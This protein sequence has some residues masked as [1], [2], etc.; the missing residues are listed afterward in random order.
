LAPAADATAD[1]LDNG[2]S[3]VPISLIQGKIELD[4]SS[5]SAVKLECERALTSL[6]RGNHTKSLRLM[7]EL[8]TKNVNTFESALVHRVQGTVCVKVASIM[9]DPSAKQRYLRNAIES[10]R[11]A[12][13]LSPSSIEFGHFYANLLYE[14]ASDGREYEEVV[15]E[16][17]RALSIEDPVDPAK[18]SL[19]DESQ[20]K[21]STKDG[22]ITHVQN[23]L[24]ALISKSNFSSIS[25]WMKTLGNGEEKFRLIPIR[26]ATEDPMEINQAPARRPN[27]I[28]KATKTPEE[29]RKEIEV[30]VAA[31]RLL[32]QKS[33]SP[34]SQIDRDKATDS[35]S[36]SSQRGGER[37]KS[38]NA[39]KNASSAE[40]K[41]LIQSFWNSMSIDKKKGLL[42]VKISDLKLHFES[43][44]DMQAYDELLEALSVAED[45]RKWQSWVCCHCNKKFAEA[46]S[47]MRHV[48]DE[49][50]TS[51]LPR[52]Q[53][54]LPRNVDNEWIEM[55]V[56]W[57]WKPL[58]VNAAA[59]LTQSNPQSPDEE[60]S[61]C[62][63]DIHYSEEPLNSSAEKESEEI[64]FDSRY[65]KI[66][67][68]GFGKLDSWPLSDDTERSKILEKIGFYFQM[69]IKHKYLAAS[70]LSKVVQ[71]AMDE[72]QGLP[73]GSQ[74]LNLGADQTPACICLLGYNELTKILKF[75]QEISKACGI[76]KY[77]EKANAG[78]R[79]EVEI[80][81]KIVIDE[82]Y[83]ALESSLLSNG[84]LHLDTDALLSWIFSGPT[85]LEQ[86]GQWKSKKEEKTNQGIEILETLE[87]E[88]CHLQN[89]CER[90]C[91]HIV[92]E[93]A[94]VAVQ[95]ICLEEAKKRETGKEFGHKSYD[96]V[97]RRREEE[98]HGNDD[99]ESMAVRDTIRNILKEAECR[100]NNHFDYD[101]S[102]NGTS[103]HLYDLEAGEDDNNWRIKDMLQRV[104]SSIEYAIQKAKERS[105]IEL[106]K[107]EGLLMRSVG[108][109]QQLEVKLGPTAHHDYRS[110]V[111]PLVRSFLRAHLED[112]AE[113][114]ATEKSNAAREAFL[115]ELELD[116]KTKEKKKNKEY[117]KNKEFKNLGTD[118][119]QEN[120]ETLNQVP[121][122]I[123]GNGEEPDLEN[124]V[125]ENCDTPDEQEEEIR[126]REI[127]LEAEE[128]KL[129]ET[130]QYQRR[131]EDEAKQKHLA[132]LLKKS[133]TLLSETIVADEL[134]S[135][136]DEPLLHD[137]GHIEDEHSERTASIQN[138]PLEVKQG[139]LNGIVQEN[140]ASV[141]ERRS[142]RKGRRHKNS[143]TLVHPLPSEKEK[144]KEAL[145]AKEKDSLPD[146]LSA[147]ENETKTL[148]QLRTEEDD[149]QRFQA[150]LEKA[151]QQS[152]DA[153]HSNTRTPLIP[154]PRMSEKMFSERDD[155][156]ISSSDATI[157][158]I[159]SA[160]GAGL[161]NEVGEYNCFL[162]VIIQSLWHLRQF[163]DVFLKRSLSEHFHVGDPCVICALYGIFTSMQDMQSEPVA[164]TSLRIALSKLYP[165]NNFFQE[166][167]MNDA[168]EVLGVIFDCLHRSFTQSS[169]VSD[170]DSLESNGTGSW[171]CANN[172]CLAHSLFGMDI[173]EQMNCYNCSLESRHLKYTSFF[174]NINAN[175]LRTMKA[176]C[177]ESSFDE[178]LNLVEM[179][180]QLACDSEAGGC[181]KLN[182]IHHILST[183]PHIFTTV[184]GWQ[185]TCE[186]VDDIT[187][188]LSALF[189]EIDLAVLYRGVDPKHRYCLVSVVCYYGQHYHCFAYN[190]ERQQWAMYDDKSV[191]VI[192]EWDDVVS[193]CRKG[194]LQPQVLFFEAVN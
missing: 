96:S 73:F 153:F 24:H 146:K 29:I 52:L 85:H 44:K 161:K 193:M 56:N 194:H 130:L 50:M 28:K 136:K 75:V 20:L 83:L 25:T 22:R 172:T 86:V 135:L 159:N 90:K 126:R 185:T 32:Q 168:S 48:L 80:T 184:L 42:K 71:F 1:A 4:V 37:R 129:E 157:E 95:N 64:M 111:V 147:G 192:G 93:Q 139:L 103:S 12:V 13:L 127:E 160:Y 98:L 188:T 101:E 191:K 145:Q 143:T 187:E 114:A 186:S 91:D 49:H 137:N 133:A 78:E 31:A 152:L 11:K 72:L 60:F 9:D 156:G 177:P 26:R 117:R 122:P 54:A 178:V 2:H 140:G 17:E 154:I 23:E 87:K 70:H 107:T 141:S 5:A 162:N 190:H 89:L 79:V 176:M 30:R 63:T 57:P 164:P 68:M 151:V 88:M 33:D 134:A 181:G 7:K 138:H 18:E 82:T 99:K 125:G 58:D 35:S 124:V 104:D 36:K 163:R 21:I 149:E 102:Y 10:A 108:L 165:E 182:Y 66:S 171:D 76:S 112:L 27:E 183:P 174:H 55:L 173:F 19:Q 175:A 155:S 142:G 84:D 39:R 77:T 46:E 131:I 189:T 132:E 74:L 113:K 180:H 123:L 65:D 169:G 62:F 148:R 150:D 166:A 97:L 92:E 144:E 47:H 81:E 179:N 45:N 167:Q 158:N 115:A 6:R 59:K 61:D 15:R 109:V 40:R 8:C 53:S 105:A 41:D 110:I 106:S 3:L 170:T 38:S 67:E 118:K 119:L 121:V 16:C 14:V 51:L 116:E 94:L 43:K 34:P 128:R 100:R 120:Y 69:L